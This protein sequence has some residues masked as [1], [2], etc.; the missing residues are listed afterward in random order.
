MIDRL[1]N[2]PFFKSILLLSSGSI[3]AQGI[4]AI[5]TPILTRIYSPESMGIYTY[6]ISISAI[7]MG[8]A[9][10]RYEITIVT[11]KEENHVF[12]LIKLSTL[13]GVG[14]SFFA[15]IGFGVF[16]YFK[17]KP[18]IWAVLLLFNVLAYALTNVLTAYNNRNKE[19]KLISSM[20]IVRT[21]SQY[22]LAIL[23][24]L[25]NPLSWFLI[26][27]Y[28]IGE[29]MGIS[30]QSRSLRKYIPDIV[31]IPN[32]KLKQVAALHRKQPLFSTPALLANSL[33]Y[34]LI[35]IFIEGLFGLETVGY[36]SISVSLLGL[37]LAVIGN[38]ISKVFVQRAS[39][40]YATF[41]TYKHTFN[42]TFVILLLIAI[43]MVLVMY[44]F[45]TPLCRFI[46]GS[47]WIKSGVYIM[48]LAPMFG[49]RF[50]TSALSPAFTIIKKQ[51]IELF[52]QGAFLISNLISYFVT[53]RMG[54]DVEGF[55]SIVSG[56]FSFAYVLYLVFI[57]LY[58]RQKTLN[59]I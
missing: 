23:L 10:L 25:I 18:V 40:E 9:N 37:P 22:I 48:I 32:Y 58:S 31:S 20:Y 19:Y 54:L 29:F 56:L 17:G 34:S 7:F 15:A 57:F 24:G 39:G 46:F 12:S 5:S 28:V 26:I 43:P 45:A 2:S 3:I 47:E 42:K 27:P 38:N 16:F 14:V 36:Y 55:L 41:G 52:L 1:K 13:I 49:V 6:L 8:I 11:D 53:K 4:R 50:I 21:A 35:T 59:S 33:S 51:Q 44:F 30:R